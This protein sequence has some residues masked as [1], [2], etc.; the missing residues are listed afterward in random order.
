MKKS[1]RGFNGIQVTFKFSHRVMYTLIALTLILI[2]SV[3]VYAVAGVSHDV[4]ELVGL[5]ALATKSSIAWSDISSGIPTNLDTDSTNDI[6]TANIGSQ[7]VTSAGNINTGTF[8]WHTDAQRTVNVDYATT[9]GSA[10]T[11]K[12]VSYSGPHGAGY[13]HLGTWG[14][15]YTSAGSV[16]VNGAKSAEA[17]NADGVCEVNALS[18]GG[19]LGITTTISHGAVCS[20]GKI[21]FTIKKGLVTDIVTDSDCGGFG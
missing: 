9:S 5:G 20:G 16:L 19:T 8:N 2:V 4:S 11:L 17:C 7:S 15:S 6:T 12:G 18:V 3:G 13:Y 14:G 10:N 1:K 21:T